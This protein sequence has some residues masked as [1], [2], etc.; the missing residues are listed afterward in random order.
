MPCLK[1]IM[2]TRWRLIPVKPNDQYN[3]S[4]IRFQKV[5]SLLVPVK[6]PPQNSL[7]YLAFLADDLH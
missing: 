3:H 4:I 2:I 6:C 5:A 7:D 1:F